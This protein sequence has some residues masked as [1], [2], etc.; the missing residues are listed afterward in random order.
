MSFSIEDNKTRISSLPSE[1]AR[2]SG[3]CQVLIIWTSNTLGIYLHLVFRKIL[4]ERKVPK[5]PLLSFISLLLKSEKNN[6]MQV[7]GVCIH[8]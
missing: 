5:I 3:V 7:R 1:A 6:R 8:L 2:T 4:D